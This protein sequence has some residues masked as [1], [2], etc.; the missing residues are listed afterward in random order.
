[1]TR[2]A[3]EPPCLSPF[4]EVRRKFITVYARDLMLLRMNRMVDYV[5]DSRSRNGV[6]RLEDVAFLGFFHGTPI[7]PPVVLGLVKLR[8]K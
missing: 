7:L 2:G 3:G 6:T 8:M 4:W 1:M 5:V